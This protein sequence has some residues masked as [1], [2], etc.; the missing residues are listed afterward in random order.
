MNRT[1]EESDDYFQN[2]TKKKTNNFLRN[3]IYIEIWLS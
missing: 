3:G 1:N 2:K